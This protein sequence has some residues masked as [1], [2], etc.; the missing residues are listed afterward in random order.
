MLTL[1]ENGEV[2]APD[3]L[4]RRSVL[5]ADSKIAK[6]GEVDPRVVEALGVDCEVV[7]ASGCIV[8]PG[9]IDPHQHL[10][11]G[12]GEEGFS[13]QTP[14]F[15]LTEIVR[16]GITSVVGLLGTDTTMKTLPGLLARVKALREQ[17]LNAWMWTGGYN[18]PP[19][20]I[21]ETVREDIMFVEEI[22]GVG[23]VAISDLRAMDPDPHQLAR[24]V[25]DCYI[26][27]KLARKS[28]VTHFHVGSGESRLQPLRELLEEYSVEPAWLYPTH[29][30]RSESLMREAID[31][32]KRG[33]A[34]DIDVVEEDLL[35]WLRFYLENGG[36][37]DRLTV[38]SDAGTNS[39]RTLYEQVCRCLLDGRFPREQVLA[40]VTRNPARILG[41]ELKGTLE[42]GKEGDVVVLRRDS[43]DVVHVLSRGK[44]MVRDGEPVVH[45]KFLEGSNRQI[46]MVG[47]EADSDAA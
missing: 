35:K 2:Y 18:V 32:A 6:V 4:G 41:L 43:L 17:G 44:F 24:V 38:S 20:S 19:N 45:E 46:H 25:T 22:I 33:A 31:L 21:L 8:T 15:F 12:S 36:P 28:R 14:E 11:G 29:I 7:D 10:L 16:W 26:G 5:L 3:P 47:A 39:P 1:I 27:G 13:S 23:E 9:F 40:V 34:V 30:E 37:P 42:K